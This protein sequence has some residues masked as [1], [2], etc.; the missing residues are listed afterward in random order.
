VSAGTVD[1]IASDNPDDPWS[2]VS[3]EDVQELVDRHLIDSSERPMPPGRIRILF[4]REYVSIGQTLIA[5]AS[6]SNDRKARLNRRLDELGVMEVFSRYLDEPPKWVVKCSVSSSMVSGVWGLSLFRLN[7]RGYLYH[8]PDWG[9]GYDESLRIVAAWEP[10]ADR[11]AWRTCFLAAYAREWTQIGLPPYLGEWADGPGDLM[12]DA[13][14]CALESHPSFW[15]GVADTLREGRGNGLPDDE[16]LQMVA[17]QFA[18]PIQELGH[19]TT[20]LRAGNAARF[21]RITR[22]KLEAEE[23]RVVIALFLRCIHG[24]PFRDPGCQPPP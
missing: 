23:G 15:E 16:Q 6:D 18:V 24:G 12:V 17:D 13:V 19:V 20:A 21:A 4:P 11:E 22:G 3:R 14:T 2:R 8:Q 9:V 7:H 10:V 5:L 1:T